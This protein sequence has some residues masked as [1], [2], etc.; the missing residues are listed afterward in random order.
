[1]IGKLSVTVL[2]PAI[3][4][5]QQPDS[6]P[7][8]R[9]DSL[10]R[11]APVVVSG[12]R[13]GGTDDRLPALKSAI[14]LERTPP[15]PSK[16]ADAL[17]KTPGVSLFNDQGNRAQP[18]FDVRGF[19]LSPVVGVPQGVSVFLDGVRIN[20]PDAQ[21]VN[22]DLIPAEAIDTAT[23]VR[24]ASAIYGKN[25]LGG[26]LALTT[27]RGS[28][29]PRSEAGVSAGSF[30]LR[31]VYALTRG[32]LGPFDAALVADASSEAGYQA[33]SGSSIRRIFGTLGRR[34]DLTDVAWSIGY[35]KNRLH[36]AGSLPASWIDVARRANYTGG[37]FFA[38]EAVFTSVRGSRAFSR[39]TVRGNAFL[40][41]NAVEQFNVNVADPNT[42]AFITNRSLGTTVQ[43]DL[44]LGSAAAFSAG[45]E[46]SRSDVRYRLLAEATESSPDLPEDC[47][48]SGLCENAR[49]PGTDAAAF[50]QLS[51]SPGRLSALASLRGD[52]VD[53]PFRD[54]RDA[55]NDG[56]NRFAR[57]S[58]RVGLT[59]SLS[60]DLRIFASTGTAFR[61][62]AP[63]ELAC[64][65]ETAQCPLPFSLGADPPLSP[66]TVANYEAGLSY[67][68][69]DR[70][71]LDL[72]FY[73]S[74]VHH[75]IAFVSS[76]NAA[77]FFQ[78][79]DRTRRQGFDASA[80]Y[81]VARGVRAFGSVTILDATYQSTAQLAS[82]LD[83]NVVHAG[84]RMALSPRVR[85]T[86]GIEASKLI[87]SS[88]VSATLTGRGTSAQ[89]LRGDEADRTNP[90]AGFAV[91][92]LNAGFSRERYSFSL[93]VT[94]LFD[95]RYA[96]YGV[97]ADNP[98]GPFGGPV[99]D[100]PTIERFLTPAYPRTVALTLRVER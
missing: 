85:G 28:S 37:D 91:A 83:S 68:S 32:M 90:L 65:S 11:L 53:V 97:Y 23:L 89:Y 14:E 31:D 22:F 45:I 59:Y 63:L 76:T 93:G 82:P 62:P 39:A 21:E 4:C 43:L 7:A 42:R 51:W 36:E 95:R 9:P 47:D 40:R 74:D 96:Q 2:A 20:E 56:T 5:A 24:G 67:T 17:S 41:R 80:Q 75:D 49:V 34:N 87:G 10:H 70:A 77:G 50:A 38:P 94:N 81:S 55:A 60:N 69:A 66:V 88:I 1:M 72:A 92:D 61:A 79:L 12:T 71:H 18:S 8:A 57:L 30:G 73:R 46:A 6:I 52:V 48:E 25:T 54:L 33:Q 84:D 100:E 35:A 58:P 64:A 27:I 3:L 16:L 15:G 98:R 78:N 44:S 86:A 19:S 29:V 99:P 13:L 26:A